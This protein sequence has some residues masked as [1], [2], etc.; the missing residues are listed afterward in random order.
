MV[1]YHFKHELGKG[2]VLGLTVN[3]PQKRVSQQVSESY[4]A[5]LCLFNKDVM[6]AKLAGYTSKGS[7]IKTTRLSIEFS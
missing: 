2:A 4:A 5:K 6:Y 1:T 3:E 7:T